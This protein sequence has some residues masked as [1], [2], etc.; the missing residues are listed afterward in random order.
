MAV[1]KGESLASKKSS[2]PSELEYEVSGTTSVMLAVAA[3]E[4]N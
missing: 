2:S 4:N 3:T 1:A